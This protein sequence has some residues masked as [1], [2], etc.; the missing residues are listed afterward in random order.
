[1]I[2]GD[3]PELNV[4]SILDRGVPNKECIAI[5]VERTINLGQFGIMLGQQSADGTAVPYFDHLFWFGDGV[6]NVG[7]WLFV[8]TGSGTPRKGKAR[9]G[10]N[11]VFSVYWGKP[12]TVFASTIV[13]PILFRVDAVDI[14]M[15]QP[16]LPQIANTDT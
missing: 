8:F 14:L 1:M 13:A 7:D 15:P 6:V 16:N 9:N 3:L 10:T 11:D 5:S 2:V 12:T 4:V